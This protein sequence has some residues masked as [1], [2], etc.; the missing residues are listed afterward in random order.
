MERRKAKLDV[1][2]YT[3]LSIGEIVSGYINQV[4]SSRD[5]EIDMVKQIQQKSEVY[6]GSLGQQSPTQIDLWWPALMSGYKIC[7]RLRKLLSTTL[8]GLERR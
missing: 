7:C 3:H 2:D 8:S 6:D 4:Q 1:I 5:L